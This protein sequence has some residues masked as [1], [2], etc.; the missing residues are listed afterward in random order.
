MQI[1]SSSLWG[2][3]L[4]VTTSLYYL[5]NNTAYACNQS[6]IRSILKSSDKGSLR[7]VFRTQ[8]PHCAWKRKD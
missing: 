2:Q 1:D 7:W 8:V 6:F 3:A 5:H 4:V